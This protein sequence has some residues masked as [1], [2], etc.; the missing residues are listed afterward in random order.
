M[1]NLAENVARQTKN[2]LK[3]VAKSLNPN[4]VCAMDG[5]VCEPFARTRRDDTL[6]THLPRASSPNLTKPDL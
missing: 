2:C 3:A 5:F 4:R 6:T 1:F